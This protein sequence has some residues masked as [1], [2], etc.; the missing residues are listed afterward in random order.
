MKYHD[1]PNTIATLEIALLEHVN[2][3]NIR[4]LASF[5]EK[6]LPTRKADMAAVVLRNLA[7][8]GL[9]RAWL[10]L[11]G[12]QQAAVAEAVHGDS[13]QFHN[14]R[15]HAKY[16]CDPDWGGRGKYGYDVK[17]S[18]LGLFFYEN[19][20]PDDLRR[21]L[22][23]FV[24]MPKKTEIIGLDGLPTAYEMPF[25]HWNEELKAKETG[26]ERVPLAVYETERTAQ[27][28]LL[29]FLRLIDAGKIAVS[30]K[31]RRASAATMNT[32]ASVLEGGDFYPHHPPKSKWSDDNAGPI[33]AFAWPLLVQA[34]GLAQLAGTK[35]QLTRSGRKA[36]SEPAL[37]TIR[38]LLNKWLGTTILDE[39]SRIDNVK[40]QTGKGKHGL[41]AVASRRLV[42]LQALAECPIKKWVSTKDFM[43]FIRAS[44]DDLVVTRNAW[45]LYISDPQYG[46]LGYDGSEGLLESRYVMALLLEYA[47][48]LGL[49]DAALIPPAE[50]PHDYGGLWGADDLA[51]LSR[52]DGLMYFRLTPLGAWCLGLDAD[53]RPAPI[54]TKAVLRVLPNLDIAAIGSA[55]EQGDRIALDSYA[56][57][58]SDLVWRLE[59]GKL[60]SAADEGRSMA[61]IREF[62]EARSGAELPDTVLRLIQDIGDR[63]GKV[64]DRGLARLIEC[65]DAAL[66]VLIANDSR[67]RKHC[68]PAGERNLVVPASEEGAFKRTLRELGYLISMGEAPAAKSAGPKQAKA[69]ATKVKKA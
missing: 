23:E 58:V 8:E 3:D 52:Y 25:E 6:K 47:A 29:S 49:I 28:E 60:L 2:S 10:R 20:M 12:T 55:L 16:G 35:L 46:S 37:A 43:R 50:A 1:K 68:L 21:R 63:S 39:L 41:T 36:L 19:V 38:T 48:T 57:R 7:G 33:R 32:V 9:R 31:T 5:F 67:T 34:G 27:R 54:E 14:G 64:R 18:M 53:Y 66:A 30:D 65:D 61:E 22:K 17:P 44:S 13:P 4:V 24:P 51:F 69:S 40:G 15:F 42:V 59:A 45:H 26:V 62:L 56:V 11:D